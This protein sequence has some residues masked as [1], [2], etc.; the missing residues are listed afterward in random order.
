MNV[1]FSCTLIEDILLPFQMS[2]PNQIFTHAPPTCI[3][4]NFIVTMPIF[5]L[6]IILLM[7][8]SI[9]WIQP[10]PHGAILR[11]ILNMVISFLCSSINYLEN[12]LL[13]NDLII[14][15]NYGDDEEDERDIKR[16]LE[17]QGDAHIKVEIQS[18]SEFQSLTSS[19]TRSTR[20]L[21]L[22]IDVQDAYQIGFGHSI[23]AQK[24]DEMTSPLVLVAGPTKI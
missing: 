6:L 3:L 17:R 22:Q 2:M 5:I 8:T 20:P 16:A 23:Y 9:A 12:R 13:C 19:P 10:H 21:R 18:N 7:R 24:E 15:R 1:K 11:H 14:I 4:I